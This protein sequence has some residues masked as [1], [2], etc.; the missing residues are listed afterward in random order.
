M[1][2]SAINQRIKEKSKKNKNNLLYHRSTDG[3]RYHVHSSK[4]VKTDVHS[5]KFVKTDVHSSKVVNKDVHS[6][7]VVKIDALI[8]TVEETTIAKSK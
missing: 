3:R 4:V 7:E 5:S 6:L 1:Y 2:K 8:T